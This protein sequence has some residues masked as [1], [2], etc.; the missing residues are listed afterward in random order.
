MAERAKWMCMFKS[1]QDP[2]AFEPMTERTSLREAKADLDT[3]IAAGTA[4]AD[5]KLVRVLSISVTGK[6]TGM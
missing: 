6:I 2:T 3:K 4:L 5:L 1:T